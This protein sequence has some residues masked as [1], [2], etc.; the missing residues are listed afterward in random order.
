[1]SKIHFLPVRYGDSL[2]IECDRDG[3][4]GVVVVDGGPKGG[5]AILEAKLLD[6]AAPTPDL[7]MLS[8][9]DED[10]IYGLL[11]YFEKCR[12]WGIMPAKEV[13]GNCISYVRTEKEPV[14]PTAPMP[15]SIRQGVTLAMWMD[16]FADAYG[17]VYKDHLVEGMNFNF[18]YA[19]FEVVGP[20][21]KWRELAIGKQ[22]KEVPNVE[23]P[24][25][26]VAT[27][28]AVPEGMLKEEPTLAPME[29]LAQ[30]K[31]GAPRASD[32]AHVANAS[33][34]AVILVT[35]DMSILLLGDSFPQTVE[36]YLRSQGYS[37]DK[38]LQVD[39]VKVAHHGSEH[40][41][42]NE[43]LDI[44]QCDH[45]LISTNGE[46][47][48][49]PHRESI[50]HILCHPKRDRNRKVH[51]YFNTDLAT[52][53][54]NAKHKFLLPGEEE[55]YNF[56]VHEC[57]NLIMPIDRSVDKA[58]V[59]GRSNRETIQGMPI[60]QVNAEVLDWLTQEAIASPHLRMNLDFRMPPED[61]VHRM[62]V[63]LEPGAE[64]IVHRHKTRSLTLIILRGALRVTRFDE[65]GRQTS[66]FLLRA[67]GPLAQNIPAGQWH[68]LEA[69]ESGTLFFE[70]M[71]GPDAPLAED[72]IK[73]LRGYPL[74]KKEMK[75]PD[76]VLK[77]KRGKLL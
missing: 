47:F 67:G 51:L 60:D 68:V 27:R 31:P 49:H 33:S 36:A 15:K 20:Q 74:P 72:E 8:H 59:F 23:R 54:E 24:I 64:K 11:Q 12:E 41:T 5:G 50:A 25:I 43:L 28:M 17:L 63:A 1:M 30:K 29:E 19:D 46:Q 52:I 39:F 65:E 14:D 18:A 71:N 56:E 2:V 10:H 32:N 6:I 21:E 66:G 4:H 73:E 58:A 45:F 38:P 42:S 76:I 62:L 26:D 40:N 44:I 13:W 7:M 55:Q 75:A 34:I 48:G 70:I 69:H 35:G 22:E 16:A 9:Y 57:A 3:H 61:P 37:E 53:E 77:E